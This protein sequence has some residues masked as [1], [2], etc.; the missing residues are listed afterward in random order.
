MIVTGE[1][2]LSYGENEK[3]VDSEKAAKFAAKYENQLGYDGKLLNYML[4]DQGDKKHN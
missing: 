1:L 4:K 3:S 2:C